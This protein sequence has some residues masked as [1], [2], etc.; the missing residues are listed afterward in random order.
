MP[1]ALDIKYNPRS[2]RFEI[3]FKKRDLGYCKELS[4]EAAYRRFE[5]EHGFL[6][7]T[8]IASKKSEEGA[9]AEV[10]VE[11]DEEQEE[12]NESEIELQQEGK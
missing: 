5:K 9:Y 1:R 4:L 3:P 12:A 7:P 6:S 8:E 10:L 2:K 11:A